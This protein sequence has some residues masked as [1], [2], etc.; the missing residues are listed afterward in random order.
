MLHCL[1]LCQFLL[2]PMDNDLRL[3]QSN[4]EM[5]VVDVHGANVNNRRSCRQLLYQLAVSHAPDVDLK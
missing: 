3:H 2:P 5:F 1:S 4:K